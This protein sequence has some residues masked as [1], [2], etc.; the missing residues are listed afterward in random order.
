MTAPERVTTSVPADGYGDLVVYRDELWRVKIAQADPRVR[1]DAD[2]VAGIRVEQP[3]WARYDREARTVTFV[4]DD[5]R[6]V[7]YRL[8]DYDLTTNTL[9]AEW[10]D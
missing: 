1:L 10:P 5:G 2:M 7:I 6:R 8:G 3:R 9:H 4:A